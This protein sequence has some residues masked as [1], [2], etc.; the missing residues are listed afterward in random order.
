MLQTPVAHGKGPDSSSSTKRIHLFRMLRVILLS[1]VALIAVMLVARSCGITPEQIES[2]ILLAELNAEEGGAYRSAN[3]R[4]AGVVELADGLQVEVI[5]SGS[6]PQP[7]PDDWVEFHYRGEHI[8]GRVFEDSRRRGQPAVVP[9]ERTIP[10]WQRVLVA[11]PTGSKAKLVIP[12]ELAYGAA[13]SGPIGPEETLVFELELLAI[14]KPPEP[15][16]RDPSQQAVP[17][18]ERD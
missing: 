17:G 1:L 15:V 10:G 18:L 12:P 3:R 6:G 7:G 2:R 9:V 5:E 16:E 11:L 4:R 14:V 13:G 8:D